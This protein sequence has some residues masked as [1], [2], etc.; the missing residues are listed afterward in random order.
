LEP[1]FVLQSN[2]VKKSKRSNNVW[3]KVVGLVVLLITLSGVSVAV[4]LMAIGTFDAAEVVKKKGKSVG[5]IFEAEKICHARIR[6]D[7]GDALNSIGLDERSGRYDKS[8]EEYQLFY[9]LNV[10][11]DKTKRTGV[12]VFFTNC[13]IS[14]VDGFVT[15]MEYL[16]NGGGKSEVLKRSDTNFIGL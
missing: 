8:G 5:D 13:Y 1:L 4:T 10:Y 14:S 12:N 11:R 3:L 7:Y 16:E 6:S 15:R 2:H 9:Q